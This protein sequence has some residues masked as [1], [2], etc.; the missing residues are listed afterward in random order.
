MENTVADADNEELIKECSCDHPDS[1]RI[2]VLCKET[3]IPAVLRGRIWQVQRLIVLMSVDNPL[4]LE[5]ADFTWRV[6]QECKS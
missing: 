1:D 2:R 5:C 6:Q 4:R 3:G